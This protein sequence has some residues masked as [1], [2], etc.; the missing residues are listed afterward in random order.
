MLCAAFNT[1]SRMSITRWGFQA[2]NGEIQIVG[3]VV[4]AAE[5]GSFTLGF[6]RPPQLTDDPTWFDAVQR[7]ME[8]SDK[9]QD[10]TKLPG[11]WPVI[12]N[13][14]EEDLTRD[15]TYTLGF[16]SDSPL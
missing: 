9:Q 10:K 2:A 1:P 5:T 12:L 14:R 7:I 13:T 15:N 11:M 16:T 3:E 8:I 4:L 6:T